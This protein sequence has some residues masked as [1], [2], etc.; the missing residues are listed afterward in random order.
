VALPLAALDDEAVL[1]QRIDGVAFVADEV[2]V[3]CSS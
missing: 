2:G 1:D 3:A